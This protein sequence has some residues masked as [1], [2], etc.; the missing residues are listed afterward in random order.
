MEEVGVIDN[1]VDGSDGGDDP[2]E[3]VEEF[4][5]FIDQVNPDDF[6]S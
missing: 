1:I 6:A 3:V 5:Q 4:R 2:D